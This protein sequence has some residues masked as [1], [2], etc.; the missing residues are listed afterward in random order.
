VALLLLHDGA[1]AGMHLTH[2]NALHETLERKLAVEE[3]LDSVEASLHE[4]VRGVS[5]RHVANDAVQ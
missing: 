3:P 5:H 2:V 4:L 1:L